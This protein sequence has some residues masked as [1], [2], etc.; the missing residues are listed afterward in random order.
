MSETLRW[1]FIVTAIGIVMLPLC[2]AML[3]RLPDRGYTLSKPFGLLLVGYTF[4]L[5]NS[6]SILPNSAVGIIL[7]TAPLIA[8]SGWFAYRERE[9][10]QAWI[11]EHWPYIAGVEALFFVAFITAVWLR[12]TVG[13][14]SGTEQPMDL[15]FVN[16]TM[17]ADTFPPQ[18]PWLSGHTV[19][20][21]Y[22][23]YLL[24]GMLGQLAS[25]PGDVAYNIG[26]GMIASMAFVGAAGLVYNLVA[27]RESAV[28]APAKNQ[29]PQ[30]AATKREKPPKPPRRS[31][32]KVEAGEAGSF[33]PGLI[34]TPSFNWRPIVFG[35]A[36]G[37]MLVVMGNLVYVLV[38][39]SAYGLGT[40]GF[41][42]WLAI[43]GL[44]GDEPRFGQ[45]YPAESYQF[46]GSTR[47]YSLD[48]AGF[49]VIT[50]F[51]MFSFILGDLHPHVMAL[52]FVLVVVALALSLFRSDEP[53]D[54]TFWL[55][56]PLLLLAAGVMLGGLTFINTWDVATMSIV[57]LAAAF[58]SNFTRVH[59][60]TGDLF[61][62]AATFALPLLVLAFVFYL[63]FVLSISGNSQVDG[64]GAVVRNDG[65]TH[66]GTR[67]VHLFIFWAPLLVVVM[68]FV[69]ARLLP[70]RH[71]ITPYM[72]AFAASPALIIVVAWVVVFLLQS[73]GFLGALFPES[74]LRDGYGTIFGQIKDRGWEWLSFF[75]LGAFLS[76]ALLALCLELTSN[77][78]REERQPALFALV[79]TAVALL[80]VLG[81]EFF[82]VGDVFTSRMNT[83]FKL[84]YQAWLLLSVAGGFS[85]YYLASSWRVPFPG[86]QPLR[87]AWGAAAALVLAGAALYP[88]AG[89]LNR[90]RPYN[91]GG[92]IV[93]G[94]SLHGIGNKDPDELAA[95]AWLN[96]RAKGQD[97]VIAEAWGNDYTESGRISMATGLPT[98]L[99]W[100]GHQNQWRDGDCKPCAG[101]I[102]AVEQIYTST[103]PNITRQLLDQYD[104]SFVYVGNL[105]REKYPNMADM[106]QMF[107]E[108][109]FE[110]GL[111]TIYR[112]R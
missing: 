93:I 88:V 56:R 41:F 3:R 38:F 54:I 31:R 110:S 25:V 44:G 64:I 66:A 101:R 74:N 107:G 22:F 86:A 49:Y 35:I 53:L 102:E 20:Y 81:C 109:V 87:L 73:A 61:V 36:G 79:L 80:L 52:P 2:L 60:I 32:Q 62:Q 47:I 58:V 91:E 90:A 67:P 96:E 23:G 8:L 6:F 94:G 85:L 92:L 21:Y 77:D 42:Q 40:D 59:R 106:R 1:W 50:E 5:L 15:M 105:E 76:A 72:A 13:D 97:F 19:A 95:I 98:I 33:N 55:Q 10:L 111:A 26:L 28:A 99:G 43:D 48:D 75:A 30:P 51:P 29:A 63:P 69:L 18:D 68:P 27:I 14:I 103:D 7:A 24:V 83:V 108:P 11:R 17:Q 45:W 100:I 37:L 9:E 12:T 46:F 57:V 104:V 39:A 34:P 4:W 78:D 82:F 65:L 70:L 112:A 71:R 16:A 84:Y 89:S